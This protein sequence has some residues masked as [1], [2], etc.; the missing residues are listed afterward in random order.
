M[1]RAIRNIFITG[2][3]VLLPIGG[4]LYIIYSLFEFL[5]NRLR[6]PITALLKLEIP[7]VGVLS[8]LLLIFFIG[9]FARNFIGKKLIDWADKLIKKIPVVKAIYVA[10]KQIVDTLYLNKNG[11]FKK[12]VLVEYPRKGVYTIG[13]LTSKAP[14]AINQLT[15]EKCV[16]IFVP[17]T[18]NPTS[19]MYIIVPEK[20]IRYLEIDVEDAIKLVVSGGLVLPNEQMN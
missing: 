9:L 1:L 7:G 8:A 18:P 12:V 17:T 2:I 5:D 13:F 20:D 15:S 11:S 6:I 10:I 3:I 16:S 4:S 14:E 19:G